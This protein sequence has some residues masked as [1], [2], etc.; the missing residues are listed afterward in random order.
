MPPRNAHGKI[1]YVQIPTTDIGR[2]AGILN[3]PNVEIDSLR[4]LPSNGGVRA[5]EMVGAL[6]EWKAVGDTTLQRAI[7]LRS[8][9]EGASAP[10]VLFYSTDAEPSQRPRLRLTYINSVRFGVP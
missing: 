5:I 4:L 6:R 9:A 1:C 8:S 10:V 3:S 7:V 2:S